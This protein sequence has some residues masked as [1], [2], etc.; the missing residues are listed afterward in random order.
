MGW[1]KPLLVPFIFS[2]PSVLRLHHPLKRP[3]MHSINIAPTIDE[4]WTARAIRYSQR[5]LVG[6]QE[7]AITQS[8][9]LNAMRHARAWEELGKSIVHSDNCFYDKWSERLPRGKVQASDAESWL[10]RLIL[11]ED[12]LNIDTWSFLYSL[13]MNSVSG[14]RNGSSTIRSRL[15]CLH[16]SSFVR[17]ASSRPRWARR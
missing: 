2:T 9:L 7:G 10:L 6:A 12:L 8:P 4:V 5:E 11:G 13:Y 1:H 14:G 17:A 15:C 16:D 3:P